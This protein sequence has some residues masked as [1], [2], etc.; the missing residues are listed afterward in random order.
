[1]K[2]LKNSTAGFIT[3]SSLVIVVILALIT[4]WVGKSTSND[5]SRAVRTVSVLYLDELAGRREQVVE[6]NL[7]NNIQPD[8]GTDRTSSS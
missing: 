8:I 5:T 2:K 1:M 3:V 7:Q 4:I 6:N